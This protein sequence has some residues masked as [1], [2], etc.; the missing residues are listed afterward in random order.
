MHI[1]HFEEKKNKGKGWDVPYSSL[2]FTIGTTGPETPSLCAFL[3]LDQWA[4]SVASSS[5]GSCDEGTLLGL[6][7]LGS[8]SNLQTAK[9]KAV[10][11]SKS[12]QAKNESCL[13]IRKDPWPHSAGVICVVR[14]SSWT[15]SSTRHVHTAI[16]GSLAGVCGIFALACVWPWLSS[17]HA[18]LRYKPKCQIWSIKQL[19][20]LH[21]GLPLSLRNLL[22]RAWMSEVNS[23]FLL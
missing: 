8:H 13:L 9:A 18:R 11:Q 2:G 1:K 21:F 12:K 10:V 20:S 3:S 5:F 4:S 19:F 14:C 17:Q 7:R 6:A 23:L 15:T 22:N 16:P